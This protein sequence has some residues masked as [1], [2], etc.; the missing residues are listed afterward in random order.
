VWGSGRREPTPS[1]STGLTILTRV[2]ALCSP[3]GAPYREIR[4]QGADQ[5]QLWKEIKGAVDNKVQSRP[6]GSGSGRTISLCP[7][8]LHALVWPSS[9]VFQSVCYCL[10]VCRCTDDAPRRM[11][12]QYLMAASSSDMAAQA[13]CAYMPFCLTWIFARLYSCFDR[14]CCFLSGLLGLAWDV[15]TFPVKV[16]SH[17]RHGCA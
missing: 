6:L 16:R 13:C 10:S 4:L 8:R 14:Y 7:P 17:Q 11:V 3:L 12:L 5:W 2:V 9:L 15:F 1:S